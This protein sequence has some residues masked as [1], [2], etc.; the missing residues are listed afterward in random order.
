MRQPAPELLSLDRPYLLEALSPVFESLAR[1]GVEFPVA[2]GSGVSDL[3][4]N[5]PMLRLDVVALQ[6]DHGLRRAMNSLMNQGLTPR[7]Q[8]GVAQAAQVL[9]AYP[10]YEVILRLREGEVRDAP[11]PENPKNKILVPASAA[12]LAVLPN[13]AAHQ[14]AVQADGLILATQA[15]LAKGQERQQRAHPA[16]RAFA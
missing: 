4:C 16:V 10:G 7:Y 14:I 1:A 9:L 11:T 2:Y 12:D 8:A 6:P 3:E 15:Y 13:I 5:Q